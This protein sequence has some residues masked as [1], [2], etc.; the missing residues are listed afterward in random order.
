MR[1]GIDTRMIGPFMHGISRYAY[2]LI[3][4]IS[5]TDKR[6]DYVLI[7]NDNYLDDFVSSR[8]NFSLTTT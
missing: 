7:S 3:K 8:E 1:I 5:G 2:N 4:G 6:N